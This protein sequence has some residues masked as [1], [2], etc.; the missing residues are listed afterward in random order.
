[1]KTPLLAVL[2]AITLASSGCMKSAQSD[3]PAA[4]E[5]SNF[6][7]DV[8]ARS[9]TTPVLVDFWAPWCGPCRSLKPILERAAESA[10][11]SWIL[12]AI[13][14]D[15]HPDLARQFGIQSIPNVKLFWKG[16]AVAEFSGALSED[17]FKKWM[18]EHLA[19]AR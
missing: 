13:N 17:E 3:S 14:V 6:D 16:K 8:L 19:A 11:G 9:N 4:H 1:M 5:I 12:L 18:T 7:Q 2:A 15:N 10:T